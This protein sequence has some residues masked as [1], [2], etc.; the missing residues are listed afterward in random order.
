MGKQG[1]SSGSKAAKSS[2]PA[3]RKKTPVKQQDMDDFLD[4]DESDEDFQDQGS[5]DNLNSSSEN[6]YDNEE[7]DMVRTI[8]LTYELYWLAI[9]MNIL[10]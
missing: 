3:K 6:E 2:G 4:D 1:K 7:D 9:P 10:T 5:D 8:D